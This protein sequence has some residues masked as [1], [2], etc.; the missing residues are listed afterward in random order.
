MSDTIVKIIIEFKWPITAFLSFTVFLIVFE[1]PISTWIL[2]IKSI[3][4]KKWAMKSFQQGLPSSKN[5]QV[6]TE[7]KAFNPN[8]KQVLTPSSQ[9]RYENLFKNSEDGI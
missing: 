3:G 8:T 4:N 2:N 6:I 1:S 7:E 9:P 5:N